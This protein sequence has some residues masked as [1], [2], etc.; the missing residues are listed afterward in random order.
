M[1]GRPAPTEVVRAGTHAPSPDALGAILAAVRRYDAF[2]A[3][4]DARLPM[5]LLSRF[6]NAMYEI[7]EAA[8]WGMQVQCCVNIN[9]LD[10][11]DLCRIRRAGAGRATQGTDHRETDGR[12][13]TCH[14]LRYETAGY[15]T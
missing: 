2:D 9:C 11:V 14:H 8:D 6:L 15:P 3:D 1:S 10:H 7:S 12:Q 4:N 13:R 5:S